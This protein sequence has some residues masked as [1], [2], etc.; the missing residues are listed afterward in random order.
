MILR[1]ST[2]VSFSPALQ[3]LCGA[4]FIKFNLKL[5]RNKFVRK[6]RERNAV[7]D[8]ARGHAWHAQYV[9]ACSYY[10]AT[11]FK[12]GVPVMDIRSH[13]SG[14][15]NSIAYMFWLCYLSM[16]RSVDGADVE[17]RQTFHELFVESLSSLFVL[18]TVLEFGL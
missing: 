4:I 9:D 14:N 12:P 2:V 15:G 3:C 7:I 1:S 18:Q 17:T 8:G 13:G 11:Q 16:K 10:T 6:N 5:T